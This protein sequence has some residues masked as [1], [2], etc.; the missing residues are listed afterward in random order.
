MNVDIHEWTLIT[1]TYNNALELKEWWEGVDLG[2]ATWFVVD[3]ASCD[4]T[5]ELAEGMGARVIRLSEN[6]GFSRA[7]NIA[8]SKTES[9]YV[10]FVNPD[11]RV[12]SAALPELGRIATRRDAV[13]SPQ[14]CNP[15]GTLQPNGRGLPFL[16]DKLAHRGLVLPG[17]SLKEY[18]PDTS[19]GQTF[20]AWA[21]GAAICAETS[22][23][24]AAG[25][26]DEKYFLYYEDHA[27]GLAAWMRGQEVIIVP[28]VI[29]THAWKRETRGIRLKPWLREIASATRFYAQHPEFLLPRRS[30]AQMRWKSMSYKSGK[31]VPKEA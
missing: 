12:D 10:A 20:V 24:R 23:I 15:D 29:W 22:R 2:R 27:F 7:N 9:R 6:V 19:A 8:L 13:V 5:P 11:V 18:L 21:M 4:G 14:L 1:V 3:N 25:G 30:A 17:S 28:D 26:W 31:L 16:L